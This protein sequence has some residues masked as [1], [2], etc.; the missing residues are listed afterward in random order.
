MKPMI[1]IK[2]A[3]LSLT[4]LT[5]SLSSVK[6]YASAF[7]EGSVSFDI[8]AGAGS[9]FNQNYTVLGVGI[10]YYVAKGLEVGIDIEHWFSSEPSIT[11]VSP[12]VKFVF[13]ELGAIK[14]YAGGFYRETFI[15][16]Q[17]EEGS[18][19]FRGGAFFSSSNGMN[20]GAGIVY[21]EYLDCVRV[22]ECSTTYT[23]VRFSLNY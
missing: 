12:Q 17:S 5:L 16:N 6:I 10:G 15:N 1:K 7:S 21:E 13:S 22:V 2:Y 23:D 4:I 19:G 8:V 11:K 3:V 9:A 14:P 18:F 20:I